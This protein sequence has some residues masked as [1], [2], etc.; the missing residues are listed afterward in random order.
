MRA[1]RTTDPGFRRGFHRP[2]RRR[3]NTEGTKTG[4]FLDQDWDSAT[5][6]LVTSIHHLGVAS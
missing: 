5:G 6:I 2:F 4:G 3:F 1:R